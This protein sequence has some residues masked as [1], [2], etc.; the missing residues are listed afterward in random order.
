MKITHHWP[1]LSLA[2]EE[3]RL[4]RNRSCWYF[5]DSSFVE[6][7]ECLLSHMCL[8]YN[9]KNYVIIYVIVKCYSMLL[10]RI[11]ALVLT[12]EIC[13]LYSLENFHIC[14]N[15][16]CYDD[17]TTF[18]FNLQIRSLLYNAVLYTSMRYEN[19]NTFVE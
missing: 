18:S 11:Y 15:E 9:K 7:F 6:V 4:D 12:V 10:A 5:V 8:T 1:K 3:E 16:N 14:L 19:D 17:W 13:V 2:V